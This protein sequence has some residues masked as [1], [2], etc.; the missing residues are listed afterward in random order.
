MK[1]LLGHTIVR[2]LIG[3]TTSAVLNLSTLYFFNT[4][5]GMYYLSAAIIA[6]VVGTVANRENLKRQSLL[7]LMNSLFGLG[8]NTLLLYIAVSIL[9]LWVMAGQVIVGALV[10]CCT[11]FVSKHIVFRV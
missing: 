8:L 9:G 2:Y 11:F 3:G 10:A 1:Q 4:I 7:Y 5:V 6:F